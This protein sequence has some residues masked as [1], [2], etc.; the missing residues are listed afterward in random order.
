MKNVCVVLIILAA[1]TA[2]YAQYGGM[3]GFTYN[4]SQPMSETKD[5]IQEFSWRGFSLQYY[6]FSSDKTSLG[7]ESGWCVFGQRL[8]GVTNLPNGAISGTQIRELS[9]LPFLVTGNYY[10]K[11]LGDEISPYISLGLGGYYIT[12]K[13]SLG[14]FALQEDNLHFGVA[15]ELGFLIPV[16]DDY[17]KFAL[18]YNRAVPA[19][20]STIGEKRGYSFMGINV[21]VAFSAF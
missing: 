17:I 10:F 16:G 9:A 14:I 12:D 5:W 18:K 11:P 13:L 21:G 2:G 4:M 6:Y 7:L 15:P 3:G 8:D 1:F 20:K 19:G